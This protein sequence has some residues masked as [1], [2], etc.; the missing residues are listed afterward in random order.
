MSD[1]GVM[2]RS[3]IPVEQAPALEVIRRGLRVTPELLRGIWALVAVGV[4]YSAGQV[5]TPIVMQL[6]IDRGGLADGDVDMGVVWK[7]ALAG[8]VVVVGTQVL[9]VFMRRRMIRRAE[10]ALRTLRTVTFDH[11]HRMSLQAHNRHSTGVLISRITAD[12]DVLGRFVDWGM[13]VWMVQPF[14]L[15]GVFVTMAV[16]SWQLALL[17]LVV[18]VPAIMLMRWM[19]GRMSRAHLERQ[20]TVGALL[21]AFSET[22]GGAHVLRAYG[23][24]EQTRR[25]LFRLSRDR[26]RASL[27]ANIYMSVV[28]VIGDLLVTLVSIALIVVGITQRDSLGLAAGELVALVFL[29]TLLQNPVNELGETMN[30]AQVA[31]AGWRKVLGL[32]EEPIDDLDPIEG[33]ELPTGALAVDSTGV[34]FAYAD[35]PDEPILCDVDVHIA[36][37]TRTAIVG[38]TGSGKTTFARLLCRLADPTSGSL[39]LGGVDLAAAGVASRH[40]AVRM[41]PQDSFLFDMSIRENIAAGRPDASEADIARAIATLGLGPWISSLPDGLDTRVGERG[42]SLSVG[43]R[44]LVSFARASVADPGLLILDEATSSVDP[45]TDLMLT[46]A[47][48]RLAVGRT[49]VSIAHRMS[50]AESADLVLVFDQGR[51]VETGKHSDLVDAGGVYADLHRAWRDEISEK[52]P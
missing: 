28:F 26:Y 4:L 52:Q 34:G 51:L 37:G 6:A 14:V 13:F 22:L 42:S 31:V 3:E 23:A 8:L 32:L 15:V 29:G 36:A 35:D 50:T 47:I 48:D 17:A 21:G 24:E 43:E 44:Q 18:F 9:G 16:Y 39:S 27:R 45:Q 1:R 5:A 40:R 38:A 2:H 7:L 20:E 41:V 11:V 12:I 46:S 49:V 25:R 33:D 10:Q 19:Q 30:E